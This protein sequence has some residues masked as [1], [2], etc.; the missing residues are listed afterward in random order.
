MYIKLKFSLSRTLYHKSDLKGVFAYNLITECSA[1][2][3]HPL[4]NC[5]YIEDWLKLCCVHVRV[6]LLWDMSPKHLPV[7]CIMCLQQRCR[8]ASLSHA[9]CKIPFNNTGWF[10]C[11]INV[12]RYQCVTH[13]MMRSYPPW[14]LTWG[15][16]FYL[17]HITH[18]SKTGL[19]YWIKPF[20]QL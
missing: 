11:M 16:A 12:L 4:D 2:S 9:A 6:L 15:S 20:T 17:L 1:N 3:N 19:A 10:K 13:Q 14:K 7:L 5:L 8:V 18:T